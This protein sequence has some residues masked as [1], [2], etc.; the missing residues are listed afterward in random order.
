MRSG[1]YPIK[2]LILILLTAASSFAQQ[3]GWRQVL[4][5]RLPYFGDGNWIVVADSAFPLRAAPGVEMV[6]S[7][8]S[9]LD[10]VRQL[11]DLL[12]KDAHV[13]P[14]IYTDAELKHVPEQDAPGIDAFRQLLTALLE[15][16]AAQ[17][18]VQA[19]HASNVNSVNEAAKS[20]NVLIIKTNSTLPYTPVFVELKP[21]Y[22]NEETEQ[23]LRQSIQ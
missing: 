6:I 15:K 5:E 7:G 23:R 10:T 14:I 9:H 11:L 21:G 13:R 22:W 3:K 1:R 17:P 20:L 12:A 2:L 16:F 19:M 8:D 4:A 18:P